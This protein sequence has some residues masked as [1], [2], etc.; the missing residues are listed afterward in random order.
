MIFYSRNLRFKPTTKNSRKKNAG[1][2]PHDTDVFFSPTGR[3]MS[4]D[5]RLLVF[6]FLCNI[7]LRK[8]QAWWLGYTL[9]N[10]RLEHNNGG[11]ED[12]FPLELGDF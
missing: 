4:F 8:S 3:D 1:H 7:M 10:E 2:F 12:D 5:P 9:E 11:L 6:E